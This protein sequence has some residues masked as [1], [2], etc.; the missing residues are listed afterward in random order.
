MSPK[1]FNH[2]MLFFKE[3]LY[4]VE[5]LSHQERL[6][7]THGLFLQARKLRL[8]EVELSP[9]LYPNTPGGCFPGRMN[10]F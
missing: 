5:M 10:L 6:D 9:S 8:R 2:R 3:H 4:T 1:H 7:E